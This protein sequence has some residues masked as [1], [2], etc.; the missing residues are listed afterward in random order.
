ME[1]SLSEDSA[2]SAFRSS[3]LGSCGTVV[4]DSLS[5]F[6]VSANG[7]ASEGWGVLSAR[8]SL[9]VSSADKPLLGTRISV[10]RCGLGRRGGGSAK[11][12][13]DKESLTCLE[14]I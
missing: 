12:S 7:T 10:S 1:I 13:G 4:R 2:I 8:V 14:I 9:L 6:G 5:R 3:A 11:R